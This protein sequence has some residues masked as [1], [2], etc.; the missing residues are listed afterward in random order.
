MVAI[1]QIGCEEEKMSNVKENVKN[2][3]KDTNR[4]LRKVNFDREKNDNEDLFFILRWSLNHSFADMIYNL[5]SI[6]KDKELSQAQKDKLLLEISKTLRKLRKSYVTG[7][8]ELSPETE[9]STKKKKW[10]D[11]F[12]K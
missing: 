9:K 2:S 12:S 1:I 10:W 3:L 11:K 8:T 6:V 5:E 4:F 7:I